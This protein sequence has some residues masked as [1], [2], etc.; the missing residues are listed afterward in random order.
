MT[1]LSDDETVEAPESEPD[2]GMTALSTSPARQ[3]D[4][5]AGKII[6]AHAGYVAVGGLIPLPAI[7]VAASATVQVRMAA[8]LCELYDLPFHQQAVKSTVGAFSASSH[9]AYTMGWP[10][11]LMS[12][13][14]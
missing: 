13:T 5:L 8:K 3:R 11:V 2:A 4:K 9:S 7:D 1:K 14:V 10:L 6:G 12:S